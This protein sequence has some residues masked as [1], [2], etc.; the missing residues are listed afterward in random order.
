MVR[1]QEEKQVFNAQVHYPMP[2]ISKARLAWSQWL[3]W[4]AG[5]QVLRPLSW[6]LRVCNSRKLKQVNEMQVSWAASD[7][8]SVH[9][10][11]Q[12]LQ[13]FNKHGYMEGILKP[14]STIIAYWHGVMDSI[15]TDSCRRTQTGDSQGPAGPIPHH[16]CW[17]CVYLISDPR[18]KKE[19]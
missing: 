12:F 4:L 9:L 13:R 11:F 10:A 8:P 15:Y 14:Q 1:K 5:T 2:M 3:T 19:K 7:L 16:Y 6:P 17:N 18:L